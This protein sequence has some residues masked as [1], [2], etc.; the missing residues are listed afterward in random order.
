[1]SQ[2][3]YGYSVSLFI[4]LVNRLPATALSLNA[5]AAAPKETRSRRSSAQDGSVPVRQRPADQHRRQ[6][7]RGVVGTQQAAS[8]YGRG[9]V[10]VYD[11]RIRGGRL[12]AWSWVMGRSLLARAVARPVRNLCQS[13]MSCR[14][15]QAPARE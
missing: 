1:M 3:G 7:V 12:A 11:V 9:R 13:R 15:R 14:G 6:I 8:R 2:S 5:R 4:R 10:E